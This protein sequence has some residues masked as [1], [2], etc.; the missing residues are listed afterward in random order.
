[1]AFKDRLKRGWNAFANP[2][3]APKEKSDVVFNSSYIRPDRP[4]FHFGNERSLL[5]SAINRIAIDAAAATILHVKTD[6]NGNYKETVNDSLN[7]CFNLRAN[8]DQTGR[9]FVQD[10]VM[11]LCDEGYVGL[12][13]TDADI[14]PDD[15]TFKVEKL[16]VCK[17]LEWCPDCVRCLVYNENTGYKEEL[18]TK[19]ENIALIEN[20]LYSVMNER[21]STLRRLINKLNILDAIDNQSGSGKMDLIIQVPYLVNSP[22]KQ[23]IA[24]NRRKEIETQLANSKYGIAYTDGTEHIVQLNRPVENNLMSQIEYLTKMFYNQLGISENILNGTASE[25]EMLQYYTRTIEPYLAAIAN[26][27][28]W[29]FLSKTARA[30]GHDIRYYRDPFKLVPVEKLAEIADKM[31]RNEILTSNEFR[32]IIGYKPSD[33]PR[34]NQLRNPNINQKNDD[35]PVDITTKN[36]NGSKNSKNDSDM[37]SFFKELGLNTRS[38]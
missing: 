11:S 25:Y 20:P 23:E 5:A 4:R 32:A 19:K 28:K 17:V 38:R 26:A 8:K 35:N 36:Q 33:D 6:E 31:I 14:D 27:V 24:N 7:A 34:S 1:M 10:I 18:Y 37:D 3:V 9:E 21:N 16:R 12:F 29:K 15:G 2:D 22:R 30:Q 13:I